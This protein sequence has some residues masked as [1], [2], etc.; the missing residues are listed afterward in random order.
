MKWRASRVEPEPGLTLPPVLE[1]EPDR[2][3]QLPAGI[4]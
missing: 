3:Y 1:R 2:I 4:K